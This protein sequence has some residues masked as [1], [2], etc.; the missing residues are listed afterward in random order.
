MSEQSSETGV[1]GQGPGTPQMEMLKEATARINEEMDASKD[2][3]EILQGYME[4][5]V[6]KAVEEDKLELTNNEVLDACLKVSHRFNKQSLL[7]Q[8]KLKAMEKDPK[9]NGLQDSQESES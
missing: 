8:A 2:R 1:V 5:A 7:H 3:S 9:V 4:D 6:R